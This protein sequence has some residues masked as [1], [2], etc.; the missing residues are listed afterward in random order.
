MFA[1]ATL[2]AAM[3]RMT[4]AGPVTQSPPANTPSMLSIWPLASATK[5]PRLMVM[6]ALLEAVCFHA[7]SDGDYDPI[8]R[9][10]LFKELC[11]LRLGPAAYHPSRR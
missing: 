6:L 8:R 2:P 11:L 1:A 3:A 5:A 9:D 10:A 4:V 7:L